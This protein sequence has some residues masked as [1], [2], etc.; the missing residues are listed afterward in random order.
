M[1]ILKNTIHTFLNYEKAFPH[2]TRPF[3]HQ[4]F[5]L[6][7][8]F[9]LL[10]FVVLLSSCNFHMDASLEEITKRVPSVH[11]N[12]GV[13]REIIEGET[14]ITPSGVVLK[15]SFGEIAEKQTL[16]NGVVFEGSFY[17]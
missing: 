13:P 9:F 2:I 15:G 10:P 7:R 11:L 3:I 17:E 1:K 16:S 14:I 6:I 8:I 5:F 12:D 4:Q